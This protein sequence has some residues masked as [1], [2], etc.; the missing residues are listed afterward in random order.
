MDAST[1]FSFEFFPPKNEAGRTQMIEAAHNLSALSPGFV[2]VTFGAGGSTKS[3]TLETALL[4][5]KETGLN[6]GAHLSY[7]G[8]QKND[9]FAYADHLWSHNIHHLV[10]LRGDIPTGQK[11]DDFREPDYF[12][13]T[14]EFVE[15]LLARHPFDIS[16]GA[17]PEKHPDAPSLEADMIA[18]KKKCDAGA[19]RAISQFFFDVPNFADFIIKAHGMGIETPI[20]PGLLPVRDFTKVCSFAEKCHAHIPP[21]LKEIFT[22]TDDPV[23]AG[24]KLLAEQIVALRE[25]GVTHFHFYTLNR[26]DVIIESCRQAGLLK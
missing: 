18:L 7:F 10:A 22:G 21:R 5:Q 9:L 2:T 15:A 3:G 19:T 6:V 8:I 1:T 25:F 24:T 26:S 16:V 4:L 14:S 23:S 17:Y 13:Y 11:A 20:V 12:E